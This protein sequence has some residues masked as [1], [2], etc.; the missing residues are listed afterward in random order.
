MAQAA[1]A[2][3]V[4]FRHLN[5]RRG[6]AVRSSRAQVDVDAYPRAMA[7]QIRRI[8]GL[9]VLEGEVEAL[10]RG[11]PGGT[12][13]PV[14]G[15]EL[16][17]GSVVSTRAVVLTTGTFLAA[18]MHEGDVRTEGGR[19]GGASAKRLA[20]QLRDAGLRTA[21]LKTGTVPRVAAGTVDWDALEPQTDVVPDGRLSHR[22]IR[23]QVS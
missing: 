15:V 10:R 18:V 16:A 2:A 4:Q 20:R 21:R 5:T 7:A 11:G 22:R 9:T 3:T 14:T 12:T 8:P 19:R 17:D 23:R 13:G 1:D 6:L